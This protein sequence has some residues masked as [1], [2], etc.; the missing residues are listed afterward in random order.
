M[1]IQIEKKEL[2]Q[3]IQHLASIVPSKNTTPIL[4]NYLLE[5]ISDRNIL[6]IT[7]SDLEITVIAEFSANVVEN[8]ITTV[9]ARQFNE[10]IHSLPDALIDIYKQDEI[11]KI[12]CGKIDFSL[13]CAD[14][15][16]FP[17]IPEKSLQNAIKL[18]SE[19]FMRMIDKT[20]FAVSTDINRAVLNGVCWLIKS[21]DQ[22]MAATDGRKV[23]EIK[24]IQALTSSDN[25]GKDNQKEA[26]EAVPESQISEDINFSELDFEKGIEKIL[27][28]KTLNFLEKIHSSDNK[29]LLAVLE[30]NR[31]MFAYGE[32]PMF[33]HVIEHKY[34]DYQKA[35]ISDLPNVLV[36]DKD[37]LRTAIR[38]ISLIAPEDNL[39][40][41]FELS[42]DKFEINTTHREAG[43]GKE[44]IE[45][46]AY[47]GSN[48]AI[49]F[50]FKYMV[51]ILD[52]I[53]TQNV[54]ICLGTQK[55]PI[56]IYN[57]TQPDN[58][59]ITYLLMPLRS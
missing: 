4:T 31:V 32:Y 15:T 57:E 13:L 37:I 30:P 44:V 12:I 2:I 38:R 5:A 45:K 3:H 41:R 36:M 6:R 51:S 8:G 26:S 19:H 40:I 23:A 52:A 42:G 14:H 58:Q 46:F 7:A 47:T 49:S 35:F 39:R 16:L 59:E 21:N 28:I 43:E 55:D 18:S 29:E 33:T 20:S 25:A 1:R 27:P 24:F 10:I 56:M 17:I 54:K 48:T 34:P 22:L 53:D 11:I 9:S 50:N